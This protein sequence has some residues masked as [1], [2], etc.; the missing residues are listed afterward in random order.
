MLRPLL[1][2]VLLHALQPEPVLRTV[3]TVPSLLLSALLHRR[4]LLSALRQLPALL[5]PVLLANALPFSVL[6]M[7]L[8]R[9]LRSV[10]RSLRR[11]SLRSVLR[12]VRRVSL[13]SVP[14]SVRRLLQ[15]NVPLAQQSPPTAGQKMKHLGLNSLANFSLS[16]NIYLSSFSLKNMEI[17]ASDAG[18]NY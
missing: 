17:I 1:R 11:L 15:M 5:R 12:S 18:G 10:L 16:K 4:L 2:P 13:R 14:R 8:L 6:R 3:R 7:L 9:S